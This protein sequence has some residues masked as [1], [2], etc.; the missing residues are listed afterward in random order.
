MDELLVYRDLLGARSEGFVAMQYAGFTRL[1]PFYVGT[2]GELPG[3]GLL[4]ANGPIGRFRARQLGGPGED[5]THWI[6]TNKPRAIHAQFGLGGALALP[7]AQQF[8]LPLFVTFHGGD[9]TKETHYRKR[10]PVPTIYQR[11]MDAMIDRARLIFCV[12]DYLRDVLLGRG[13]PAAKLLTYHLGIELPKKPVLPPYPLRSPNVL[14]VA[15]LV[16]KKGVDVAIDAMAK[17]QSEA[18]ELV[19]G[20][21]GDGPLRKDLEQRARDSGANVHFF[22]WHTP[23]EVHARMREAAM[24]LIPS[25]TAS[26]GDA[27][28]LGLVTLEA[29]SV[30]CPVI[31]S[32]H[33]GIP[34]A[35][36]HDQTGLLVPEADADALAAA[37]LRM[38]RENGLPERLRVAAFDRLLEDF[39]AKKQSAWLEQI[40]LSMTGGD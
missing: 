35:V 15:R 14:L 1:K 4:I 38:R 16:E 5:L 12:S 21:V 34:E 18:P 23:D 22:G 20:I 17:L 26:S 33:G 7:F 32:R 30:G 19:L 27:E 8:D 24:L 25:R 3:E 28:G 6:E 9:A 13:F 36:L 10:W 37:I 39:D 40:L 11:R 31:G 2:R 29:Q